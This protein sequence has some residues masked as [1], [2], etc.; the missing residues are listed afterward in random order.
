MIY[1]IDYEDYDFFA[2]FAK[3]L[4]ELCGKKIKESVQIRNICVIC[5]L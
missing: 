4:C 5:V 3:N 1:V 2:Y